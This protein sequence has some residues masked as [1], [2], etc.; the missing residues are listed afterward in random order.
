MDPMRF[1][2]SDT[3]AGYVT[4]YNRD[5]DTFGLKTTDGR[6]FQVKFAVNTYGWIA[7]NLNEPRTWTSPDQMR[8]LLVPGRYPLCTGFIIPN[9]VGSRMRPSLWSFPAAE[10]ITMSLNG[11]IGGSSRWRPLPTFT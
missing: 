8:G 2:F 5:K 4:G 11:R 6:D 3:I 7:N 10:K 1:S 9:M